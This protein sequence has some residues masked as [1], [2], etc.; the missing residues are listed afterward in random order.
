MT[1]TDITEEEI[2]TDDLFP[3]GD[4]ILKEAWPVPEEDFVKEFEE[5]LLDIGVRI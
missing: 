5:Y 4:A 2:L 1:A 3:A